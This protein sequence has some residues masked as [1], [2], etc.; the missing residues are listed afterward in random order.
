MATFAAEHSQSWVAQKASREVPPVP[1]IQV[2]IVKWDV[3][4]ID[5]FSICVYIYISLN[6]YHR[7][8]DAHRYTTTIRFC[9]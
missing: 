7:L 2:D 5:I 6:N 9:L 3:S 4:Q 8:G 1:L